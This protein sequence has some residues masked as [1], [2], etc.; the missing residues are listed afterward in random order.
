MKMFLIKFQYKES[1]PK[2]P[3]GY[4]ILH[5][6]VLVYADTYEDA[7]NKISKEYNDASFFN[8]KTIE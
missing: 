6:F 7:C 8:N 4:D 5:T 1:N 3:Y 2:A